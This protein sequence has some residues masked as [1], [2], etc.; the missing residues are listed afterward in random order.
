MIPVYE[1][2]AHQ[3]ECLERL[4]ACFPSEEW[5]TTLT[6][7]DLEPPVFTVESRS[8]TSGRTVACVAV[9]ITDGGELSYWLV[10]T[11]P[12]PISDVHSPHT[13]SDRITRFLSG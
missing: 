2:T 3:V 12:I 6:T 8:A 7:S 4:A 1:R 10:K 13:A 5:A 9:E 11:P